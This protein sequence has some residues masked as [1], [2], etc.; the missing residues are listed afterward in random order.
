MGLSAPAAAAVVVCLCILKSLQ[1]P[2]PLGF[3]EKKN[4]P[5]NQHCVEH[6]IG[7]TVPIGYLSRLGRK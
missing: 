4:L 2:G 6:V 1:H 5:P 3:V 7:F